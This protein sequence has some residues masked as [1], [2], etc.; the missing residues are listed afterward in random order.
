MIGIS[1]KRIN[2]PKL[3]ISVDMSDSVGS[4]IVWV[5]LTQ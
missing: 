4:K 2:T 5:T 3:S 1:R